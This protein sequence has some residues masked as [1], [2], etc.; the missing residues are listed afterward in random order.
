MTGHAGHAG[1]RT[2]TPVA[3]LMCRDETAAE[4]PLQLGYL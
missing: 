4:A 2:Q 1:D 3:D